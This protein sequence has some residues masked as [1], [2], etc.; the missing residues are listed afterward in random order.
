MGTHYDTL[1]VS[2]DASLD[3][4]KKAFRQR[5]KETHPDV[6]GPGANPDKF[7]RISSAAS[8]LTNLRQ[9][10][11]YDQELKEVMRY[12][13]PI[14]HSGSAGFGGANAGARHPNQ[15]AARGMQG[16]LQTIYRP[17]NL[18]LVAPLVLFSAVTAANYFLK[19]DELSLDNSSKKVEAWRNP[20]TGQW[21]Q[22]APWDPAYKEYRKKHSRL[23]LVPRDQVRTREI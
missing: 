6:A 20:Q 21:E 18:F 22:P 13:R 2:K 12:G 15:G 3:D 8:V 1:G 7:K 9:R 5:S 17:F 16:V 23:D 14:D 19:T 10:Q 4:I 11:L